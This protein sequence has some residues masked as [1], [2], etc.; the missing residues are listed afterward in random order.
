M[1]FIFYI[2]NIILNFF[3]KKVF[4]K[5]GFSYLNIILGGIFGLFRGII[6]VSFMLFFVFYFKDL[7]SLDYLK[8]SLLIK[9][10]LHIKDYFF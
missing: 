4:I 7:I 8:H 2:L 3:L 6:L 1:F 10:L 5:I 9:F